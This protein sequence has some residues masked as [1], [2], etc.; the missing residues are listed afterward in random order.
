MT[1]SPTCG[2]LDAEGTCYFFPTGGAP[3]DGLRAVGHEPGFDDGS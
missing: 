2:S 1:T 3:P